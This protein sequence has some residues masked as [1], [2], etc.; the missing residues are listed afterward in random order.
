MFNKINK[1][2][3][4][5]KMK[6]TDFSITI[7]TVSLFIFLFSTLDSFRDV[8]NIMEVLRTSSFFGCAALGMMGVIITRNI[9]LS[10]G[11]MV[12]FLSVIG[13]VILPYVGPIGAVL[14]MLILGAICGAINGFFVEY[15]KIDS[16]ILTLGMQ[17]IYLG[18]AYSITKVTTPQTTDQVFKAFGNENLFAIGNFN[19]VPLPFLIFIAVAIFAYFI[20]HRS[21]VGRKIFAVGNNA[22]AAQLSGINSKAVK[23]LTFTM[24]GFFVGI[25]SILVSSRMMMGLPTIVPSFEFN[26]VIIVVVGG[27]VFFSGRG[28]VVNTCISAIFY[29]MIM[30]LITL[31]GIEP[32]WQYLIIAI[33]LSIAFPISRIRTYFSFRVNKTKIKQSTR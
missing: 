28:S 25:S 17:Y 2:Y 4:S 32:Q 29:A 26:I 19:G 1:Y 9:D 30:N 5:L 12:G 16:F 21:G 8:T 6:N 20:Y 14:I 33:L 24:L 27:C 18:L 23:M 7:V 13:I 15:L 10:I 11:A 22:K 31:F 3:S